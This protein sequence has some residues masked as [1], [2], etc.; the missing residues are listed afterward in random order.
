MNSTMWQ[1]QDNQ[2]VREFTFANFSEAFAFMT[3]VALT[4]EKMDHHPWWS[5]VYNRVTIKLTTHDA[6][7]T[8]TD[9]DRTLAAMID[10]ILN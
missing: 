2:L 9:K 7:N 10:E 5:N 4:A 1:E 8:I 6:G 3:R